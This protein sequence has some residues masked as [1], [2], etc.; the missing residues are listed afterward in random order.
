MIWI[1][2]LLLVAIAAAWLIDA[3]Q[4][5]RPR[6]PE[7]PP[8]L[9][10]G[11][12]VPALS[13]REDHPAT[14]G[15]LI[16][17]GIMMASSV[18]TL[19]YI[20]AG[21]AQK[22]GGQ[23]LLRLVRADWMRHFDLLLGTALL[24]T[25]LLSTSWLAM[26][27]LRWAFQHQR[28]RH[29]QLYAARSVLLVFSLPIAIYAVCDVGKDF[30]TQ[31]DRVVVRQMY[32]RMYAAQQRGDRQ[33]MYDMMSDKYRISHSIEAMDVRLPEW[34]DQMD[35][36]FRNLDCTEG[37]IIWQVDSVR[38]VVYQVRKVDGVWVLDSQQEYLD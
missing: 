13:S 38:V 33:A 9:P 28:P 23:D 16:L 37:E 10:L 31:S 24:W 27:L 35:I 21:I 14:R 19:L 5:R 1:I 36:R 12:G 30:Y 17:T 32:E 8:P 22:Y 20:G 6:Q 15:E 34:S 26:V 4:Q 25:I 18:I 3:A 29:R 7:E 2:I 11:A